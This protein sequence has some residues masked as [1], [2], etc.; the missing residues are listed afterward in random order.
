MTSM[1]MQYAGIHDRRSPWGYASV[2]HASSTSGGGTTT[3]P[4]ASTPISCSDM[5]VLW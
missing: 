2:C 4:M 5:L 3:F 1:G